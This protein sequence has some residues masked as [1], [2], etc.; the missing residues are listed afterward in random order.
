[1]IKGSNTEWSF[2]IALGT[3]LRSSIDWFILPRESFH[4]DSTMDRKWTGEKKREKRNGSSLPIG[5][6]SLERNE[7]ERE[8]GKSKGAVWL[9]RQQENGIVSCSVGCW[10]WC[11]WKQ[12]SNYCWENEIE[13]H[14]SLKS[15]FCPKQLRKLQ[16]GSNNVISFKKFH[17]ISH[18]QQR[19]QRY[20]AIGG[21]VL[22][23][24]DG[25]VASNCKYFNTRMN[26]HH[27]SIVLTLYI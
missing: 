19:L 13:L 11:W 8:S 15:T 21:L 2:R 17:C 27:S 26:F 12:K 22:L 16:F 25:V 6:I 3:Q 23:S 1:M 5:W 18:E 14:K 4:R 7:T 24:R 20:I 9:V 10:C